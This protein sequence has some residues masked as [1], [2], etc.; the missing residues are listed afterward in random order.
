MDSKNLVFP[1]GLHLAYSCNVRCEADLLSIAVKM[2][3]LCLTTWKLYLQPITCVWR[4]LRIHPLSTSALLNR[5]FRTIGCFSLDF[6]A[7][8]PAALHPFPSTERLIGFALSI[9]F[10][11]VGATCAFWV[12]FVARWMKWLLRPRSQHLS[13]V[14]E[15]LHAQFGLP[16]AVGPP[17]DSADQGDPINPSYT[18]LVSFVLTFTDTLL[19][20]HLVGVSLR[21]W[22]F[23]KGGGRHYVVQVVRSPDGISR[24]YRVTGTSLEV[25]ATHIIQKYNV[26][27]PV[28]S[29]TFLYKCKL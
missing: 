28:S 2:L 16:A 9:N 18:T 14:S 4:R 6:S 20:L 11:G 21:T 8:N 24:T 22:N 15:D 12:A 29:K 1:S 19:L 26:D 5:K 25:V 7:F 17:P 13:A 23:I 27:F 3:L 10:L